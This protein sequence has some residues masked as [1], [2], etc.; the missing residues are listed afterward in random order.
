MAD[1]DIVIGAK[2]D[3]SAAINKLVGKIGG[4]SSSFAM[5]G[6][7]AIGVGAAIGGA[8]A[9]FFS[10]SAAIDSVRSAADEIDALATTA[11]GIGESVGKLQ[12]FQFAMEEAGKV[13][14]GKSIQA[15]Q[16]LQKTVGEVA[17]GGNAAGAELFKRLNLDAQAL[18]LQGPIA[19]FNAVRNAI[20]GIE[21]ISER[22]AVAQQVFGKSA[23]DLIPA[24]TAQQDAFDESTAA[25]QALGLS[26]TEEGAAGIAGMNQAIG[27]A[28]AGFEGLAN[29]VAVAVAPAVEAAALAIAEFLPPV[30]Q[31]ATEW[32]PSIVDV[33]VTW[34]GHIRDAYATFQAISRLD[35]A[36]A[37][38]AANAGSGSR[39][40]DEVNA[41]RERAAQSARENA[42]K[43]RQIAEMTA[44]LDNEAVEKQEAKAS[45]AEKT[46]EQLE[47]QLRVAQFGEDEVKKQEQIATATND[48]E[49]QRIMILQEQLAAQQALN[50]AAEDAKKAE[51]EALKI[52][53]KEAED[54]A[55]EEQQKAEKLASFQP[56][57]Q[58]VESRLLTR[59]PMEKGID[60]VAVNTEKTNSKLD[61]LIAFFTNQN[62]LELELVN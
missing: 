45:A 38:V 62:K 21:N 11:N 55:K 49:R 35:F 23:A 54:R 9:A 17:G 20:A 46:A 19:Q 6:P 50:K 42:E 33:T 52:Q 39:M 40:L 12:A 22:A 28:T 24:L 29:Q 30:I 25:A 31:L 37:F 57:T 27:R 1:I 61:D 5:L 41:A 4:F 36:G 18:S 58:A 44:A 53:R 32:L 10:L 3:A 2:D 59:G 47:R 14:A 56:G 26:V 51:E 43:M 8:A 16:K 7:I 13:D 34:A 48:A 60:K 15:L